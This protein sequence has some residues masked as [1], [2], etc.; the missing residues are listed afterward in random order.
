MADRRRRA[1]RRRARVDRSRRRPTGWSP[2]ASRGSSD[3][4][5]AAVAEARV[6]YARLAR[7]AR[8]AS[9]R[10]R[11]SPPPRGCASGGS[12]CRA[13]GARVRQAVARGGRRRVRGDRLP[14]V[15]R[16]RRGSSSRPGR[17]LLQ[18]PGERNELRYVPRGVVAV[19][20]PW[21]FPLAIP[22]GMTAAALADRQRGRAQAGRAVARLRARGWSRRCGPAACPPPRSRWSPARAMSA[23][24]WCATPTC[25]TIAFTGSLPVGLEIVRAA[26]ET[27]AGSAPLQ[28]A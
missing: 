12:S 6:G 2:A 16:A 24:R 14:R 27:V 11:W 3:E 28:A 8:R 15:L 26:A 5:D 17:Q 1:R 21:N 10:V 23:R 9:A 7:A 20:S 19:I 25:T 4:V 13:R 18:V 22:C